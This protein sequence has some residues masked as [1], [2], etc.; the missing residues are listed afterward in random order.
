[1][2]QPQKSLSIISAT[3]VG[4]TG[5]LYSTWMGT[6]KR[7]EYPKARLAEGRLGGRLPLERM[8]NPTGSSS[9]GPACPDVPARVISALLSPPSSGPSSGA[10]AYSVSCALT[11]RG[12]AV[13]KSFHSLRY[14][15]G[16]AESTH[17][18]QK[19]SSNNKIVIFVSSDVT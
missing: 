10:E 12:T 2:T 3:S 15:K 19:F 11:P 7:L 8:S 13:C 16:R 14:T 17:G 1:M 18:A 5:Q 9:S 4:Y 6:T